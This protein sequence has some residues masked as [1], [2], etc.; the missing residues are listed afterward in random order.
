MHLL[1]ELHGQPGW[2][3]LT[4]LSVDGMIVAASTTLLA[5]SRSGGRGGVPPWALLVVGSVASLVA[6][7]A[8]I[9]LLAADGAGTNEIVARTGASKPTVI[10]WKKRYAAEG[11]GGLDDRPKPGRPRSTDDVAIVLATLEPPPERLGVTALV[12]PPA[13]AGTGPVE[14]QG[15]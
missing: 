14:R 13:G 6:Q 12:E 1:V 3:A 2:A 15:R 8:R 4:L 7:R 9:V 5:E 11:V 10:A